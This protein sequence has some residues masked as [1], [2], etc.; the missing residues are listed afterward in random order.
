MYESYLDVAFDAAGSKLAR[1]SL[2]HPRLMDG[3][4]PR[5]LNN[6]RAFR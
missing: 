1:T 5:G 4:L 2:T 6:A 3:K